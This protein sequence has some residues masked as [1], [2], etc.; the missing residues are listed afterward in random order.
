MTFRLFDAATDGTMLGQITKSS[1][2]VEAG[3][4]TEPL[5]FPVAALNSNQA[6]W[7]EVVVNGVTLAERQQ[8]TGSAY[9]LSTRG[10]TVDAQG[11]VGI[12][13]PTPSKKLS[14]MGGMDVTDTSAQGV[15]FS[16]HFMGFT[17]GN[18]N[19]FYRFQGSTQSHTFST[20]GGDC[21]RIDSAGRLGI[22]TM[23]PTAALHVNAPAG[24]ASVKLPDSSIGNA[25]LAAEPG[26]ASIRSQGTVMIGSGFVESWGSSTLLTQTINAPTN[27]YLF[28]VATGGVTPQ[29]GCSFDIHVDG[30]QQG[31]S[32]SVSGPSG[33][34]IA[35]HASCIITSVRT[36]PI[37]AGMHTVDW[38]GY[39]DRNYM[40]R[41]QLSVIFLP[42]AYGQ[43]LN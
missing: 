3:R 42:T 21:V 27:G 26:I 12:G 4:F 28:I 14:V 41:P 35:A 18:G 30:L 32:D 13:T 23:S 5:D 15:T 37:T 7:L 33:G 8:I 36:I 16:T 6:L 43:V 22:G 34:V 19:P 2:Q 9:S 25:E 17:D 29:S 39:S 11:K 20:S 38:I 31:N 1:V 10:I 40:N 24:D